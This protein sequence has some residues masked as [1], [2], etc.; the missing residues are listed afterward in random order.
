MQRIWSF[1]RRGGVLLAAASISAVAMSGVTPRFAVA[2]CGLSIVDVKHG[3]K[4]DN[5]DHG[6][7]WEVIG[8]HPQTL[9][10]A[11]SLAYSNTYSAT[12]TVGAPVVSAALGFEVGKTLTTETG[13]TFAVPADGHRW[14]LQAG[15]VDHTVTFNVK[16]NCEGIVGRGV[17]TERGPVTVR[18]FQLET[19]GYRATPGVS[20]GGA[21][22]GPSLSR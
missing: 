19:D 15:T 14:A 12:V 17:A 8:S 16:D 20:G 10:F 1:A 21:R 5:Y 3:P 9:S 11:N 6:P 18:Q 7:S 4:Y 13:A 2:A 22:P